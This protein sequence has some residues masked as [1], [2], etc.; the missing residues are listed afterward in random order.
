LILIARTFSP[1]GAFGW[2]QQ[3]PGL[4]LHQGSRHHQEL[5]GNV[6]IQL[7]HQ[8]QVIEIL[9]GDDGD[10]NVVHVHLVLLDQMNEQI[11]RAVEALQLDLDRLELRLENL[12][13]RRWFAAA[14]RRRTVGRNVRRIGHQYFSFTASRT[15]SIVW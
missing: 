1:I 9:L 5:A 6:E 3:H 14:G 12:F 11:E 8:V 7:L 10:L 4:D 15:R 13:G 2:R